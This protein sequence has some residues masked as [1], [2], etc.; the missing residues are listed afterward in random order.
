MTQSPIFYL[1]DE[2][3]AHRSLS[4]KGLAVVLGVLIAFNCVVATF[5]IVIGAF[6]VPFFLGL[7]V[8]GVVIAFN[9]SNARRLAGERVQVT[10]DEVRVIHQAG[11]R[12]KTLWSSPT[13]FTR[14]E[15]ERSSE[16]VSRVCVR[17]S[18]RSLAVGRMLGPGELG[19]FAERLKSAI[20]NAL[21]ERHDLS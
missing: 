6:P 18:A 17:L 10:H 9:V 5:M 1:D 14:V 3:R 16:G 19:A 7:D 21:D 15:V 20:S 13:A 12:R 11:E 2:L 4:R 8:I